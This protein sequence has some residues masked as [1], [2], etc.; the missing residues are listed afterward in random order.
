MSDHYVTLKGGKRDGA[1]LWFPKPEG[2]LA[3]VS[4]TK[5]SHMTEVYEI[6]DG[7]GN[8]VEEHYH[9]CELLKHEEILWFDE[10]GLP[11]E[12]EGEIK[13]KN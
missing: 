7:I 10:P 13:E 8:L 2:K 6:K 1:Y 11:I 5:N 3:V 9:E 12:F 4:V